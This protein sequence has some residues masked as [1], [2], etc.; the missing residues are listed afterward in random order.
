MVAMLWIRAGDVNSVFIGPPGGESGG[1]RSATGGRAS[2]RAAVPF[3]WQ[4]DCWDTQM[5]SAAHNHERLE[6]ARLNPVR[7]GLTA[8]AED[9]PWQGALYVLRW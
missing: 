4:A 9:L 1:A 5:R 2:T 7:K 8:R 6:Y 3:R